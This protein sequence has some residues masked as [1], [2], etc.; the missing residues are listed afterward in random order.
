MDSKLLSEL[1]ATLQSIKTNNDW[2]LAL[3]IIMTFAMFGILATFLI[4]RRNEKKEV[5]KLFED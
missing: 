5:N 2:M 3:C 1:E 4:D